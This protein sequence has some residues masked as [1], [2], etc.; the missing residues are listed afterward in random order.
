MDY[1]TKRLGLGARMTGDPRILG[2]LGLLGDR[3]DRVWRSWPGPVRRLLWGPAFIF[4]TLVF[5]VLAPFN[6]VSCIIDLWN[7]RER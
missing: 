7:S 1:W 6:F 5:L 3:L 2:L 4:W